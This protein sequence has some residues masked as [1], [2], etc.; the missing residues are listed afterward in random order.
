MQSKCQNCFIDYEISQEDTA[1]YSSQNLPYPTFCPDCRFK[2][3]LSWI[4][5]KTLYKWPDGNISIYHPSSQYN[6]VSDIEW[7]DDKVDPTAYGQDYDFDKDFFTQFAKLLKSAPLPHLHRSYSSLENSDYCNAATNLK[8]CYML[9]CAD[10]NQDCLY[11]MWIENCRSCCDVLFANTCELC[12]ECVNIKNCYN[13][14][15]SEDC[16]TSTDLLFCRDCVGCKNCFGCNGLRQKEYCIFNKQYSKEDYQKQLQSLNFDSYKEKEAIKFKVQQRFADQIKKYMHSRNT[17]NVS[18]DYIYQSKKTQHSY[19]AEK[20]EDC[21]YV[22]FLRYIDTG[23]KNSYDYTMFGIAAENIYESAWCGL[24]TNNVKFSFWCYSC[25]DIEYCYGCHNSQN[26]FGC[27]GLKRASYCIFN[28][29]YSKE[30]YFEQVNRIKSQMQ[31]VPYKDSSNNQYFYGEFFPSELSPFTYQETL[32]SDFYNQ[33]QINLQN[34]R[35]QESKAS[36][37]QVAASNQPPDELSKADQSTTSKIYTCSSQ[38]SPNC[39]TYYKITTAELKFYKQNHIPLPQSCF[40]CRN[41]QRI[42]LLNKP[43]FRL[44]YCSCRNQKC[45]HQAQCNMQIYT[46]YNSDNSEIYCQTCYEKSVYS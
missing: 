12:F 25:A 15:Y 16:D 17:E 14:R 27:V 1:F 38:S 20:C 24:N 28:K 39:S 23:T 37:E 29:Q 36:K 45:N 9:A 2:R 31:S 30:A 7:W 4:N 34:I 42:Q 5:V 26:L 21:N 8:D 33:D 6:L 41:K 32:L 22:Q 13:C 40:N 44:T 19:F 46:A 43:T 10:N 3:R 35:I 11:S 18:G